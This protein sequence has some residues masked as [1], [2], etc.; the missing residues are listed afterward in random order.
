MSASS[1]FKA[2]SEA[3]HFSI[4]FWWLCA[5]TL[6]NQL[7]NMAA[8]FLIIYLHQ[9]L[10]WSVS[11]SST[12]FA[13]Q[14]FFM[15]FSGMLI[16]RWIDYFGGRR[17]MLAALSLNAIFLF[18]LSL[19]K[20]PI[21]IFLCCALWGLA[22]GCYRPAAQTLVSEFSPKEKHQLAFSV[23]RFF[24][25]LGMSIGPAVGGYLTKFHF[26]WIFAINAFANLSAVLVIA[27]G[28]PKVESILSKNT[29]AVQA[30]KNSFSILFSD[31]YLRWFLLALIPCSMVFFQFESTLV[32]YVHEFLSLPLSFYGF[33]ITV[34]TILIV[35][36]EI[37][38]NILMTQFSMRVNLILG[39]AFLGIGFG[40]YFFSHSA[41]GVIFL[42]CIWTLGEMILF[43]ASTAY[44]ASLSTS[45]NRGR[46]MSAFTT[47]TNLGL[48]LGPWLGGLSFNVI[49]VPQF[50][51]VVGFLAFLSV[52]LFYIQPMKQDQKN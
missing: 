20:N 30:H 36:T 17:V 33:L 34:N 11:M 12:A 6:L 19:L 40:G 10:G 44:V 24:I 45:E 51:L 26:S 37:P 43:P 14:A 42:V 22:Y 38:I 7:G 49:G 41:F 9:H 29:L 23:F 18:I 8:V 15:V 2:F 46:Y 52:F 16:G 21:L 35:L 1:F 28:L 5:A 13:T 32:V 4:P 3:K 50:W 39:A 25:N 27:Y 31:S 47:S 48:L